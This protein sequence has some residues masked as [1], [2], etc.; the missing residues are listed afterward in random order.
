[1]ILAGIT[2]Y[3]RYSV[4]ISFRTV[5]NQLI[6]SFVECALFIFLTPSGIF[7]LCYILAFCIYTGVLWGLGELKRDDIDFLVNAIDF[8]KSRWRYHS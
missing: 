7:L 1:M 8:G 5:L 2:I 3:K 4:L 6:A